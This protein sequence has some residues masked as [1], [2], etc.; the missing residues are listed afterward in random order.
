MIEKIKLYS[1]GYCIQNVKNILKGETSR[2]IKFFSLF[3]LIH[4]KY[5]GYILFD[6]GYSQRFFSQTSKFPFNI[7]AKITPVYSN[8][9][10]EAITQLENDNIEAKEVKYI[11]L[12]HFH[13]DHIGGI[14]DFSDAKVI[15][16]KNA[17]K[18]VKDKKG[19]SALQKG[20]LPGLIPE[21][22][23]N[24]LIY[25]DDKKT[26]E[27]NKAFFP[28]T[29]G[30]DLFND[31]SLIAINLEGHTRGHLGLIIPDKKYFLIGDACWLTESFKKNIPPNIITNL[32]FYNR[33]K[34]IYNLDRIH[35]LYKNNPEITIIP[36]HCPKIKNFLVG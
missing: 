31:R 34:Y 10:E 13:A 8:K 21:N 15:C 11:I 6:T 33:K 4:H 3:A 27:L 18:D 23:Q 17:Y 2:A 16:F 1:T 26:I 32:I 35:K 20:F 9:E 7:Y 5:L 14:K 25:A 29:H 22:F 24:R 30:Y 28:L 36:T 12:S 19:L